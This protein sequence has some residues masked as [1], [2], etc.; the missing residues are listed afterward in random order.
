[1]IFKL[2]TFINTCMNFLKKK[3][4]LNQKHPDCKNS[5]G[6]ELKNGHMHKKMWNQM[7]GGVLLQIEI[8]YISGHKTLTRW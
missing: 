3:W 6:Q 8:K 1:M 7:G 2:G 4:N 5:C